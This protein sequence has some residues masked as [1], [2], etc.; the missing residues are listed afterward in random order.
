MIEGSNT[1]HSTQSLLPVIVF[2]L[3]LARSVHLDLVANK[4]CFCCV[5]GAVV[6]VLKVHLAGYVVVTTD[7]DVEL[8]VLLIE[9]HSTIHICV[10]MVGTHPFSNPISSS[11]NS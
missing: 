4:L 2:I 10:A 3:I 7:W 5:D 6:C 11:C 1:L 9:N 8:F